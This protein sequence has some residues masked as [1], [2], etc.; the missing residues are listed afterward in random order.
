M[1]FW[2]A[3]A[4]GVFLLIGP[5]RRRCL[6]A[7]RFLLPAV[8][9]LIGGYIFAG[10]LVSFGLPAWTM[11]FMPVAIALSFGA[12]GKA[13]LDKTLGPPYQRGP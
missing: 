11:L 6:A 13:W 7:W 9:G 10:F 8:I 3:V 5:L 1:I 12:E 2:L 4:I